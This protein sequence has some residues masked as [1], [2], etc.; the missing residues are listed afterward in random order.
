[1]AEPAVIVSLLLM[2]LGDFFMNRRELLG[3]K[4]RA[5]ARATARRSRS[6]EASMSTVAA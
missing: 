3:I 6:G 5:E 4:R 1:M 2:E